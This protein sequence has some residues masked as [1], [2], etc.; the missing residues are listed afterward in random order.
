[1][2]DNELRIKRTWLLMLFL[3]P[4]FFLV[5]FVVFVVNY[6]STISSG[7]QGDVIKKLSSIDKRILKF[8][9]AIFVYVFLMLYFSYKKQGTVLLFLSVCGGIL[10]VALF[11][12]DIPQLYQLFMIL[13]DLQN[14]V[15]VSSIGTVS[16]LKYVLFFRFSTLFITIGWSICCYKLRLLNFKQRFNKVMANEVYSSIFLVLEKISE[17]KEL[18]DFY[19]K[20]VRQHPE[21]EKFLTERYKKKKHELSSLG[22]N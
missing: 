13:S 5:C 14:S 6:E 1:M 18:D 7:V 9:F 8:F 22:A 17:L 12:C 16:F 21:I 2:N 15:D 3:M 19:A 11:I 4:V 20:N 10:G